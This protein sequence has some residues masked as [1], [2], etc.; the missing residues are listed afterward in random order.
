MGVT[1]GA[2]L[3][4]D[5]TT[6]NCVD[7]C[8]AGGN[9]T[10]AHCC[11]DQGCATCEKCV[12][13]A[14]VKEAN[15]DVKREC[16]GTCKSGVCNGQGACAN[17][18]NNQSGPGCTGAAVPCQSAQF[19]SNGACTRSN[20]NDAQTCGTCGTCNA[21]T[22]VPGAIV[23]CYKD[24]DGDGFGNPSDALPPACGT[25]CPPTYV[26]NKG[27]C[28]DTDNRAYPNAPDFHALVG[29]APSDQR[30]ICGGWD[31]NCS[32]N[33]DLQYPRT[34]SNCTGTEFAWMGSTPPPCGT[35]PSDNTN[36]GCP[37]NQPG[38]ACRFDY[39]GCK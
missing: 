4:C 10:E 3:R 12:S 33:E 23:T 29:G 17:S 19:C 5:T 25:T 2:N 15:E 30:Y 8:T 21:G 32:G 20:V 7:I 37:C 28:C 9:G 35:T 1:C 39:Q 38:P 14:C 11:T 36:Y 26:S 27:D 24:S 13:H 22:C 34:Q 6:G 16:T 31:F 18:T